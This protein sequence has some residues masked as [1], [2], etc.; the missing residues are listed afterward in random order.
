MKAMILAAGRGNRLRPLTDKRPKPLVQVGNDTLIEHHI[1]NIA[2]AGFESIV[3]NTAYMGEM[4]RNRIGDGTRY[5]IPIEYSDEGEQALETGGGISYA[6]PLLGDQPFLVVS[7]DIYCDISFDHQ[8]QMDNK[9]MHLIMVHN[10]AH[11]PNGDFSESELNISDKNDRLTYSGIAYIHPK[12]FTHE[13]RVFPLINTIRECINRNTI[14][15]SVYTGV[16]FDIGTANRLHEANKAV[17]K[18]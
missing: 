6:L 16:W 12:L 3:I 15:A 14:N 8:F 4:I 1:K 13:E 5:N 2:R 7:A 17:L 10:P 11:H 18:L 9:D